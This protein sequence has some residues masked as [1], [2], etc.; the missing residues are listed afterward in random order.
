M[1][2]RAEYDSNSNT[3]AID[4]EDSATADFGDDSVAGAVV[5]VHAGRAV[6]IDVVRP[7]ENLHA[8]LMAVAARHALDAEVLDAAAQ[9]ALAAPDRIV[10]LDVGTRGA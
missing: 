7:S 4:L 3:L 2:L 9:S 5:H 8:T 6:G 10:V 1:S